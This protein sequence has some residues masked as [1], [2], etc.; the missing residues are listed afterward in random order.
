MF[1]TIPMVTEPPAELRPPMI[2]PLII[3]LK[4]PARAHTRIDMLVSPSD[5][6]MIGHL[7]SSSDHGAQ[8]SQP[9]A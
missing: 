3:L 5:A 2:L 8:S 9:I 6:C 4:L 7:L 1:A